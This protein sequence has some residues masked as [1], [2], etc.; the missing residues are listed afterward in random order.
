[1]KTCPACDEEVDSLVL[2]SKC[3]CILD[4]DELDLSPTADLTVIFKKLELVWFN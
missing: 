2:C 1:M 3:G 4:I